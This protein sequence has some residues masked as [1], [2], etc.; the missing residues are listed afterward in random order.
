MPAMAGTSKQVATEDV[1]VDEN[2]V[3]QDMVGVKVVSNKAVVGIKGKGAVDAN[4][5]RR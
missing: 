3:S 4:G 2:V 5:H 1:V